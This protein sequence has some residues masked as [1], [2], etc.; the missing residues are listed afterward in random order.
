MSEETYAVHNGKAS[1]GGRCLA[2][3][4][5]DVLAPIIERFDPVKVVLFGSVAD[6]TDG[7]DSDIDLLV[8]LDEAPVE[9]R[10]ELMTQLRRATRVAGVPRDLLV[11]SSGDFER[12]RD[13]V[14]T[15][16]YRPAHHGLVVYD[17]RGGA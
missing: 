1:W 17:R 3:W 11:T 9:R 10:R 5:P 15:T 12:N 13:V 14:G 16:E 2:D 6:G 4:L 8:V 7:P